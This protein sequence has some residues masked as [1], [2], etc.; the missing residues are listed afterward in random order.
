[1]VLSNTTVKKPKVHFQFIDGLRG[2]AALWVVLFHA[3]DGRISQLT[4]TLPEWFVNVVFRWGSLGVAIFF[5]LSGFVIAYSLRNVKIN[6]NYFKNFALRRFVRL[7]PPYYISILFT[8]AFAFAAAYVKGVAFEPMGKP[9][10]FQR[11]FAHLFYVQDIFQLEHI[12]DVYWTLCLEVQFY[13]VFCVL[14][15]LVQWLDSKKL[16]WARAAVFIPITLLTTLFPLN[17]LKFDGRPDIFLPL[18]YSFLLGVFAYWRWQKNLKSVWFYLYCTVLTAAGIIN[19]SDFVITSVIVAILILEVARAN[20][21]EN[22]LSWGWLQFLGKISYSLYLNHVSIIGAT[23]FIGFKL[24]DRSIW[25]EFLCLILGISISIAFATLI[26]QLV[27]KPS[28]KWSR[29]IKIVNTNKPVG[30]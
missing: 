13:I 29:N 6:L 25:S 18:L 3:E 14:L 16:S 11:L 2:I 1:M 23:Y 7:S 22:W 19:T 15:S 21:I 10:S 12:D 8:L 20:R 28:I 17:V 30:T 5:V 27:E 26:W 4:G 9:L 24:L